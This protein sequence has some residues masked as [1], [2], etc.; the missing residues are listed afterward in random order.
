MKDE[1]WVLRPVI[2]FSTGFLVLAIV[3]HACREAAQQRARL[4]G[5]PQSS[6]CSAS[7]A[8]SAVMKSTVAFR[9]FPPASRPGGTFEVTAPA[10]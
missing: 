7:T 9:V 10:D 1:F 6:A 2:L 4:S 8:S 5:E 3:L